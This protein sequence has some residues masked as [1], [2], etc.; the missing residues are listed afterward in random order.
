MMNISCWIVSSLLA[1][2]FKV[3]LDG[4]QVPL[5]GNSIGIG[6]SGPLVDQPEFYA[7]K[8]PELLWTYL[9]GRI[10]EAVRY[11][12]RGY[13]RQAYSMKCRQV[14]KKSVSAFAPKL[15]ASGKGICP[16]SEQWEF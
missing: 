6:S 4:T 15:M 9:K 13:L 12:F 2:S 3:S 7:S 11:F 1:H 14:F 5:T 8:L 10:Y 16:D